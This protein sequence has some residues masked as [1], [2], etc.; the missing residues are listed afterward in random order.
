MKQGC[1]RGGGIEVCQGHLL[2]TILGG[3]ENK[4]QMPESKKFPFLIHYFQ[5]VWYDNLQLHSC[6]MN[7][8]WMDYIMTSAHRS[9]LPL[10]IE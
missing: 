10:E 2:L 1:L 4:L 5:E 9:E 8:G 6:L 3:N 7:L